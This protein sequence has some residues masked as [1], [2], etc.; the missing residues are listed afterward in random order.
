MK[1]RIIAAIMS[2]IAGAAMMTCFA[3]CDESSSTG[4]TATSTKSTKKDNG[5]YDQ[6]YWD[7]A[8]DAWDANK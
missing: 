1:K 2:V 7:A 3:S 6:E 5:G 8:R 4:T